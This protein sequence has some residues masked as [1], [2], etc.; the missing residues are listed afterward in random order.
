VCPLRRE[1]AKVWPHQAQA[2][3]AKLVTARDPSR[4][5]R[6]G[7][8]SPS[9]SAARTDPAP[10]PYPPV[11][12]MQLRL[13]SWCGLDGIVSERSALTPSGFQRL[14]VGFRRALQIHR[15]SRAPTLGALPAWITHSDVS[16]PLQT[17]PDIPTLLR[18]PPLL[19]LPYRAL[20]LGVCRALSSPSG[21]SLPRLTCI[22]QWCGAAQGNTPGDLGNA[23]QLLEKYLAL[24][25]DAQAAGDLIAAENHSQ[26]PVELIP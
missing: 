14:I 8:R 11:R 18:L 9:P 7:S 17:R 4:L 21:T 6:S 24:S 19:L 22:P 12:A 23:H 10:S 25:R 1:G 26:H 20:W 13:H 3:S 16:P 5:R 2:T 15:T